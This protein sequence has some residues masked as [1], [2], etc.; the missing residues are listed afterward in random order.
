MLADVAAKI[1]TGENPQNIFSDNDKMGKS[2]II[3]SSFHV[4]TIIMLK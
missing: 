3:F 4:K 2:K 1:N